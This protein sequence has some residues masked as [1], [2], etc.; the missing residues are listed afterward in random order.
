MQQSIVKLI[1]LSYR[2]CSTCFVHYNA[3]HQEP[4]QTAVAASVFRMNVEGG[5]V[6]SLSAENTSTFLVCTT[7]Q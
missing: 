3:H 5:N 7:K 6:L 2:H 1:S 4:L